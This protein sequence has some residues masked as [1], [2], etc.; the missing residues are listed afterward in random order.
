MQLGG[1]GKFLAT[2]DALKS[3]KALIGMADEF[4]RRTQSSQLK[5]VLKAPR[6]PCDS[7]PPNSFIQMRSHFG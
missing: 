7:S 4:L 2:Q 1:T 3:I 6:A 5:A